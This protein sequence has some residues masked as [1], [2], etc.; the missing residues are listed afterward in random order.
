MSLATDARSWHALLLQSI[1]TIRSERLL[2][3]DIAGAFVQASVDQARQAGVLS[4]E[5]FTVH[6][7]VLEAR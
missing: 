5:H 6:G 4:D 7:T 1:Y 3:G 2:Q